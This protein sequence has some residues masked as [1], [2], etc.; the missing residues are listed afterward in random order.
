MLCDITE[1][2]NN[3]EEKLRNFYEL[4]HMSLDV[5]IMSNKFEHSLSDPGLM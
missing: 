1:D 2:S 3:K 5:S 4:E